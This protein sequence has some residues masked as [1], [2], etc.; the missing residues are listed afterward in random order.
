MCPDHPRSSY[1]TKVDVRGGDL[2]S[3]LCEVSSKSVYGFELNAD[4]ISLF[5]ILGA[6]A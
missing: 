4:Q 6:I 1:L 5:R 2:E 3:K